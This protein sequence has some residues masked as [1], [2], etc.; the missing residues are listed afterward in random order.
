VVLRVI[1]GQRGNFGIGEEEGGEGWGGDGNGLR[2]VEIWSYDPPK[3]GKEG[4]G[5]KQS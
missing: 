3:V 1:G 4:V 5:I 2:T